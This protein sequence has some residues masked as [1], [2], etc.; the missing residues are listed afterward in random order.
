[1]STERT[2]VWM[3]IRVIARALARAGEEEQLRNTLV[4]TLTPMRAEQGCIL[5]ELYEPRQRHRTISDRRN[6]FAIC[7][8]PLLKSM[9]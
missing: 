8:K 9:F 3:E 7:S 4:R 5:Y 6:M 1:M 2:L